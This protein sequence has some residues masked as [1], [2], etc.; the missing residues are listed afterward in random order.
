[1]HTETE[2][3]TITIVDRQLEAYNNQDIDAFAATYSD[4]VEI[5]QSQTLVFKGKGALIERY[6]K[7]FASLSYLHATS[8][9][10]IVH[11][12]F[13]ID[14]ELAES[15]TLPSK[16][17][18]KSIKVIAAYEVKDGLICKVTFMG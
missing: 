5:Y 18:D 11:E 17:V 14:H 6:G 13:L 3:A 9:K 16:E 7:K 1:M 12:H 4:D 2:Q 8:L 15:S 10:R